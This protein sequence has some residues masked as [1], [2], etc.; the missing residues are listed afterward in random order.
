MHLI[1]TG[2]TGLVGTAVLHHILSLPAT[3]PIAQRITRVSIISRRAEIP[4]L[5]HPD[6][7]K[8]N[9]ITKIEVLAHK[10]FQDYGKDG[11]LAKLKAAGDN[12]RI[13]VIWALGVSQTL[14]S[15]E[16]QYDEI[17]RLYPMK[18]AEVLCSSLGA[19]QV[20]FVYISGEG[21]N[22]NP[23]FMTPMF[24][25]IKGK[26]ETQLL[27]LMQTYSNLRV[28]N[29]RPGG[30]DSGA[31]IS[32]KIVHQ[33]THTSDGGT[34]AQ[35]RLSLGMRVG[36]AIL[37][38][39]FRRGVYKGMHSPTGELAKVLVELAAGDGEPVNVR[40]AEAEGRTLPNIALR[41]IGGSVN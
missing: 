39:A 7:P 18:A 31:E 26:T 21:A 33:L 4:L 13:S 25:R 22:P 17:T 32:Q 29:A 36:E 6:R 1:L 28:F 34:G 14:T 8:D 40:G 3:S 20:N 35:T 9:T 37:L 19:A 24:G 12:E 10:D 11:L 16:Q 23:G 30:V 5:Q 2:A 38:P 15:S 41:R 27:N